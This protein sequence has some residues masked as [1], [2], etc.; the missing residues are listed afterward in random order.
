MRNRILF[1]VLMC[2]VVPVQ[3]SPAQTAHRINDAPIRGN[4]GRFLP[5]SGLE[6]FDR[7]TLS[8]TLPSFTKD[9]KGEVTGVPLKGTGAIRSVAG[10]KAR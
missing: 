6:F 2:S 10:R 8:H 1:T 3:P 7:D 4:Q 5:L 9:D